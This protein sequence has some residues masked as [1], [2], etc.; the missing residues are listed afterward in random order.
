M[1]FVEIAAGIFGE[2]DVHRSFLLLRER[3]EAEVRRALLATGEWAKEE[4]AGGAPVLTGDLRDS[5]GH[6]GVQGE[7]QGEYIICLLYTSDAA[8]E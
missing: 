5:I 1:S 3:T 6:S 8:D 4:I 2:S 7:P